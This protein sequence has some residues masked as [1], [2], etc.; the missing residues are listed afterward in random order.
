MKETYS[1]EDILTI[2]AEKIRQKKEKEERE[3]R[4]LYEQITSG[5]P[6]LFFKGV[7]LFCTLIA[8]IT[9]IDQFVDGSSKKLTEEDCKMDRDWDYPFHR[10]L[11]V[12]G[13]T[14]WPHF[15][16]WFDHT[17]SSLK[18]VYSP[19]LHTGKKLSYDIKNDDGKKRK[20]EEIRQRSIFTWFPVFQIFLL[21]PLFT[22]IF[23]RQSAGFNFARIVSLVFI[24]PGSLIV[25]YYTVF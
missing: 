23:K 3:E 2:A 16:D 25:L 6:W 18:L 9:T 1:R 20:H 5:T 12:E 10:V 7:V 4:E 24:F 14:F 13:Y 17:E 8:F 22:Y 21:I 11:D 15:N 19:I